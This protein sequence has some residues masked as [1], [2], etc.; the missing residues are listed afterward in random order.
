MVDI[1]LQVA[2]EFQRDFIP[3]PQQRVP[4]YLSRFDLYSDWTYERGSYGDNLKIIDG[5]WSGLS[6]TDNALKNGV[7]VDYA[8]AYI[9]RLIKLDLVRRV[10]VSSESS[11]TTQFEILNHSEA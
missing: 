5:M 4:V 2:D 3:H 9:K 10:P 8:H 7:N 1:L 11:K 6:V